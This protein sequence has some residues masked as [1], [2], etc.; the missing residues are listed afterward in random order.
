ML[1]LLKIFVQWL[2]YRE[3]LDTLANLNDT[4]LKDLG[5]QRETITVSTRKAVFGA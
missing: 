2:E 3:T 5:L 4:V 1:P